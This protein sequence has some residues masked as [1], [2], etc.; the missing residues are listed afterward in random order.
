MKSIQIETARNRLQEARSPFK[1]EDRPVTRPR[2]QNAKYPFSQMKVGQS[3]Y[4]DISITDVQ[5]IRTAAGHYGKRNGV[6]F[7]IIRD[8]AGYRCGRIA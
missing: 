7:S 1:I 8:G 2:L 3:F 5:S 6:K 4:I